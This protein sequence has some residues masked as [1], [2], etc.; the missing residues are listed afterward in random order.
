[1]PPRDVLLVIEVGEIINPLSHEGQLQGGFVFG[2]GCALMVDLALDEDGRV[3][4]PTLGDYKLPCIR[5]VVPLKIVCL[6][7]VDGHGPYGA[8]MVGEMSNIGVAPAIANAVYE[9]TGARILELPL[10]AER[11]YNALQVARD[12]L[13]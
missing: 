8:K 4:T 1:M 13:S 9:A 10:S 3:M 5:D 11:V 6:R 2:L 12:G 7:G